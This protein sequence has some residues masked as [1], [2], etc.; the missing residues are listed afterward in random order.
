MNFAFSQKLIAEELMD[1]IFF[2][3]GKRALKT[4]TSESVELNVESLRV[5]V[6]S[7]KHILVG[8]NLCRDV[9]MAKKVIM[10]LFA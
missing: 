4:R 3:S 10:H 2:S 7:F 5:S 6:K 9:T 8:K 1:T